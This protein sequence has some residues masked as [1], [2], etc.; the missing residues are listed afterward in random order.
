MDKEAL[1]QALESEIVRVRATIADMKEMTGPVEPD[2]AIG[3]LSRLDAM[4]NQAITDAALRKAEQKLNELER[5]QTRQDDPEFGLCSKCGK[6][7]PMERLLLVPESMHCV[8]CAE[9]S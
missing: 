8:T 4:N 1:I 5:M 7:I 9:R 6:A 3:R 2:N